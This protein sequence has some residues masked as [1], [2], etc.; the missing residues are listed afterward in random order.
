[1]RNGTVQLNGDAWLSDGQNE[2]RGKTL[3]YDIG[4]QRVAANP[5]ETDPGGVRITINPKE[6]TGPAP[7]APADASPDAPPDAPPASPPDGAPRP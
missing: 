6:S 5:G 2:I 7:K 3:I 4:R 1:V